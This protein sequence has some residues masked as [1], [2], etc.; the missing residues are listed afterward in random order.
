MAG[1]HRAF[2]K[3]TNSRAV[4]RMLNCARKTLMRI[5][6]LFTIDE[7]VGYCVSFSSLNEGIDT[8]S[9]TGRFT[10]S[11]LG[12][13]AEMGRSSPMEDHWETWL[14][15]LVVCTYPAGNLRTVLTTCCDFANPFR[16]F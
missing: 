2:L 3:V 14:A 6:L 16:D 1:D 7:L 13:L 9:I 8:H 4:G 11:I 15:S 5:R 10:L 12:A